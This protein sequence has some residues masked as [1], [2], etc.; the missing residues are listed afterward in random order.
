MNGRDMTVDTAD[1]KVALVPTTGL[2]TL[3][4]VAFGGTAGA[5]FLLGHT[6]GVGAVGIGIYG[7]LAA[8]WALG[9][10]PHNQ[11]MVTIDLVDRVV[12]VDAPFGNGR[13]TQTRF[14]DLTIRIEEG[15]TRRKYGRM[16]PWITLTALVDAGKPDAR[17]VFTTS[18]ADEPEAI[19]LVREL[20][21]VLAD[22]ARDP[23]VSRQRD[24]R[25]LDDRARTA[26]GRSGRLV[27]LVALALLLLPGVIACL[28][29]LK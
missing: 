25:C 23:V 4:I 22:S 29:H 10:L 7:A 28:R 19:A 26:A 3:Q 2:D 1:R 8:L 5:L 20:G 13:G 14:D 18:A 12:V 24:L 27:G 11:R 9:L 17:T 15:F 21:S 16:A 6:S